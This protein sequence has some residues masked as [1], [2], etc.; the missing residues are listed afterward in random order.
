MAVNFPPRPPKQEPE[1]T[2]INIK[3]AAEVAASNTGTMKN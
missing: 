3:E 2:P 1:K